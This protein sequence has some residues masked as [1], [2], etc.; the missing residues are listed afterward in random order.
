MTKNSRS[1]NTPLVVAGVVILL[2]VLAVIAVLATSGSSDEPDGS[3]VDTR[4]PALL[5]PEVRPI[6]IEGEQLPVY[7][8][9]GQDL[10][11]GMRPPLLVGE[12]TTGRVHTVS[13]DI[14]GSVLLVFLAH[15]CPACNQEVPVLVDLAAAGR[16]P[17]DLKVYA[18][19]TA[20][21]P[22][23][24]GFPASRW[25]TDLGWPFETIMDEPDLDRGPWKAAE[26]F[27]LTSFPYMVAIKDGVI[28]D[29]WS[30]ASAPDVLAARLAS[31]S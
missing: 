29:R 7:A 28:V 11:L 18:V 25:L 24:S 2:L 5:R 4:L 10:A 6:E 12:D 15:W 17:S 30:G 9:E 16:V 22:G 8:S 23:R 26:A 1:S 20:M 13:P 31:I 19:L 21:E 27:G 14:E 3:G